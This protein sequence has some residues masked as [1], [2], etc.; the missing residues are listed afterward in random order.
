[1]KNPT[2]KI[3]GAMHRARWMAKAIYVLKIYL[4]RDEFPLVASEMN[5]LMFLEKLR[6]FKKIDEKI[7]NA[8]IKKFS[9]HLWYLAEE[10]VYL[11]LFDDQVTLSTKKSIVKKLIIT[12]KR[13]N[14]KDPQI[15]IREVR[16]K[17]DVK[18]IEDLKLENFVTPDSHQ[19]F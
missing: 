15:K 14:T 10:T 1:M 8:T 7:A 9:S 2:F 17:I 12:R 19:F 3:P 5:D 13:K 18:K 4:F 11:S 16:A 6:K